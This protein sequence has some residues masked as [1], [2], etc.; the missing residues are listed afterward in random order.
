MCAMVVEV[1]LPE[2]HQQ[3][4]KFASNINNEDWR[5]LEEHNINL[6]QINNDH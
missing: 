5:K 1:F 6:S 2:K 4:P 3:A